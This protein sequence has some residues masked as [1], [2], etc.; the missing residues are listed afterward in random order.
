MLARYFPVSAA[1]AEKQRF[2]LKYRVQGSRGCARI[3]S[4][5]PLS[6]SWSGEPQDATLAEF[7]DSFLLAP[8]TPGTL[9][10]SSKRSRHLGQC[11]VSMRW[12]ARLRNTSP[13]NTGLAPFPPWTSIPRGVSIEPWFTTS[14]PV[15]P[16]REYLSFASPAEFRSRNI[17]TEERPLRRA[18]SHLPY[19]NKTGMRPG[20]GMII[21][22]DGPAAS[23]KG[24]LG[25]RLAAHYGLRHLDTGLIYRAVAK[26]MLDA[27]HSPDESARAVAAAEAL[28]PGRFDEA[29][30]K[31]HAVG[32][33]A[34]VVSAIPEVRAALLAF[35]RGFGRAPPGAVLDGR[36]IG[37]VVFPDAEVKIFVTASRRCARAAAP[38]SS[39]GRRHADDARCSPT[40][41][42]AT[43]ATRSRAAAPLKPAAG[44]AR[45]RYHGARHRGGIPRRRRDR[46]AR[47]RAARGSLHPLVLRRVPLPRAGL[48][49]CGPFRYRRLIPGA[50]DIV[51]AVRAGRERG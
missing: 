16:M 4:P 12:S 10:A 36:D 49:R 13:S 41:C 38:P 25:R 19:T 2:L 34:S 51:E 3:P 46:R 17:F 15:P 18:R 50:I 43:S 14:S 28:D 9:L 8:S 20:L 40:S 23:G 7:V 31:R 42:A 26:S 30:L 27:G 39:S 5:R 44:C 11:S 22:I 6:A 1:A 45:A 29:E 21:A 33:A 48:A 32:E 37:T 24:T 35:Q 47:P